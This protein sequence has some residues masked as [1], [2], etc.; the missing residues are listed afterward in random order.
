MVSFTVSGLSVQ[1]TPVPQVPLV[2]QPSKGMFAAAYSESHTP[3]VAVAEGEGWKPLLHFDGTKTAGV[4]VRRGADCTEVHVALPGAITAQFCRNLA[5]EAGFKPLVE[6][7]EL[8][9]CGSGIFYMVAQN[10]GVKRFRLPKERKPGAVLSGPS[11]K[12]AGDGL[13]AVKMKVGEIFVMEYK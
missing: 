10:S 7:D 1:V 8:C 9:G 11:F 4:S 2:A 12:A 6:S 3:E 5:R 13:Y